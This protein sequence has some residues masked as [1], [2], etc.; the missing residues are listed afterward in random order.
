MKQYYLY[1][2][3]GLRIDQNT[4]FYKVGIGHSVSERRLNAWLTA[5]AAEHG[6]FFVLWSSGSLA[7]LDQ[8]LESVDK[9]P[10]DV[11]TCNALALKS[12][13]EVDGD[14]PVTYEAELNRQRMYSQIDPSYYAAQII[15]TIAKKNGRKKGGNR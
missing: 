6:H 1:I 14:A 4:R 2:R 7:F 5:Y 3:A 8:C 10:R 11:I 15:L 9:S 13:L 12:W